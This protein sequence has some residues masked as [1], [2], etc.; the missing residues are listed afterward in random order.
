M[1]ALGLGSSLGH[2]RETLEL[3]LRQ[4]D[5]KPDVAVVR[6]SR[7]VRTPPLAGGTARN[8]F[9]NGVALIRTSLD[10]ERF[11]DLCVALE[12]QAGRRRTRHWADRPLDLDVLLVDD[13]VIRSER[14][15]VP[16]PAIASRRFVL[17]PLLDVWPDAVDPTTGSRYADLPVPP[18]PRPAPDGRLALSRPLRYL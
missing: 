10:P 13:R 18:G 7:W 14:L 11:L 9:L 12:E 1:I 17:E 5:A 15:T 16:H 6:V 3:T 8:W 4:L 2:R